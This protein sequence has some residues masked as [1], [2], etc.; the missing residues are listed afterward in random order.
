MKMKRIG[1]SSTVKEDTQRD[2]SF[3]SSSSFVQLYAWKIV[4]GLTD[5]LVAVF[6]LATNKPPSKHYN[7]YVI[8]CWVN[9][10]QF[11]YCIAYQCECD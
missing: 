1:E 4:Y 2:L 6:A 10:S 7:T 8:P 9:S 11:V 5:D 3:F